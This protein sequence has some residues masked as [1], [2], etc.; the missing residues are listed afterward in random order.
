MNPP[1]QPAKPVAPAVA[2]PAPVKAAAPVTAKPILAAKPVT[3]VTV[4]PAN[5]AAPVKKEAQVKVEPAPVPKSDKEVRKLYAMRV[6][7][8]NIPAEKRIINGKLY[9][10][11]EEVWAVVE[12]VNGV[13]PEKYPD[14]ECAS[15]GRRNPAF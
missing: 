9:K 8:E 11:G 7:V 12:E 4:A 15:K 14:H 2:T 10:E 1:V 3:P 13:A 6:P 5:P